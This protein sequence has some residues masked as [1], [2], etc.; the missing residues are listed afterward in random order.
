M[1]GN[2]PIDI[3]QN[4]SR[5]GH[6]SRDFAES[7]LDLSSLNTHQEKTSQLIICIDGPSGA[8]KSSVATQLARRLGI[9]YLATGD[10]YRSTALLSKEFG[11]EFEGPSL[12]SKVVDVMKMP[13]F[14][15]K[16]APPSFNDLA[17][18]QRV[19]I[20][21]REVSQDIRTREIDSLSS[22]ISALPPV[23]AQ[24]LVLQ[25]EWAR[26]EP[27]G[28]VTEGR[29]TATEVF[30]ESR[31]HFYLDA[32]PQIRAERRARQRL[33]GQDPS[34][35]QI[36]EALADIL[37]R[38]KRDTE[39]AVGALRLADDSIKLDSTSLTSREIVREV[40]RISHRLRRRFERFPEN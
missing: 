32:D 35:G 15:V 37:Q 5:E 4:A 20:G 1:G 28:F 36:E 14:S 12:A 7:H 13:G 23:R 10:L 34:P 11:I 19:F 2:N 25:R 16:F 24:M 22:I 39:R 38:D 26:R 3:N 31:Y 9:P 30:P 17:S 40:I 18:N 6:G 21:E 29:D 27:R 8:G 33:K